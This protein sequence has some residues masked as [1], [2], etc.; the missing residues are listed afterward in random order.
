MLRLLQCSSRPFN[1]QVLEWFSNE[2]LF[3]TEN[4]DILAV[5]AAG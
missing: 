5:R 2:D 4:P 1:Q 3:P